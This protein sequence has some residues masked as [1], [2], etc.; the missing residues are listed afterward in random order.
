MT[1]DHNRS[2]H[3]TT[4]WANLSL[5]AALFAL[6]VTLAVSG[7]ASAAANAGG[8]SGT[9]VKRGDVSFSQDGNT[10]RVRASNGAIIEYNRFSI[11]A[12]QI[13][14]FIQPNAQSRVLNRV[15]G[16]ELSRIDGSLLSNGI[17]YLVNPQ[18][19][20]IGNGAVVNVGGFYAAAGRM[21]DND[22][23]RGMNNFTNL[24]GKVVNDGSIHAQSVALVG[25]YVANRGTINVDDGVVAM[26]SGDRVLLQHGSGPVMVTVDRS[27][28]GADGSGA[29]T[30][31]GVSNVG[32]I[33]AGKGKVVLASGDFYAL[34]MDLSGTII[35]KSIAARGGAA[36][37]SGKGGEV[38]VNGTLDASDKSGKGGSIDVLGDK[39]GL[40]GKA[41]VNAN[42]ATG[43]GSVRLG[44]DY[45]GKNAEV[46]NASATFIDRDARVSAS[47]TKSGDGGR[48]IVWS[49]G[50][51][52]FYGSVDVSAAG[53]GAGGFVETSSKGNLQAFGSVNTGSAKGK[54][55]AWLLDPANLTI[56][57][58]TAANVTGS[59][60]F[61]PTAANSVLNVTQLQNALAAAR[62]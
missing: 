34:S 40:L 15:T 4:N 61:T 28:L 1:H 8:V 14:Q 57:T 22:F 9:T 13:M 30:Q 55:G 23:I 50:Y 49:D 45:L 31:A 32:T 39:V 2:A 44:G 60:P 59:T 24:S 10:L 3:R 58:A 19:F 17:V 52:G 54:G 16:S 48:V 47:A 51:T 56:S 26:A 27:K 29:G 42:G 20:R 41:V 35:G 36:L 25:Q 11:E 21:S 6:S 62:A 46:R 37:P 38:L 7:D 12:G 18:G 5:S 53:A 43:G 33:N